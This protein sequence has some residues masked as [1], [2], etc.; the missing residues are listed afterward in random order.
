M[1]IYVL[2]KNLDAISVVDTYESFIW[3]DRYFGYGDF[4]LYTPMSNGILETIQQDFYLQ[5]RNSD[6]VMIIEKLLINTDVETG[7]H[8]TVTGRS[9][10]SILDRRVVW[11]QVTLKGNL[12]SEIERLLN[13]CIISPSNVNRK[14]PNFIF[15]FLSFV[16]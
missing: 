16:F 13:L 7:N 9:L 5:M 1:D 10:E 14:I 12:Q 15:F 8:I 2:D 3:T 11:G 6:R 4:E